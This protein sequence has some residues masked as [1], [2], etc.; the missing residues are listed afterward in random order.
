MG[1]FFFNRDVSVLYFPTSFR[2]ICDLELVLEIALCHQMLRCR[3]DSPSMTAFAD[4]HGAP[5][6]ERINQD[7]ILLRQRC[8]IAL[9]CSPSGSLPPA[10]RR[11]PMYYILQTT[12]QRKEATKEKIMILE[13]AV[14]GPLS[15]RISPQSGIEHLTCR[16]VKHPPPRCVCK[17]ALPSSSQPSRQTCRI[18]AHIL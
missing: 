16:V 11:Q 13:K 3:E 4:S 7:K 18:L 2:E 10:L 12:A 17:E 14:I 15:E 1:H 5:I 8:E 6:P 9:P